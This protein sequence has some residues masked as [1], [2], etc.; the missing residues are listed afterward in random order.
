MKKV[1]KDNPC[2]VLL[3]NSFKLDQSQVTATVYWQE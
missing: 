3:T 2:L 1:I